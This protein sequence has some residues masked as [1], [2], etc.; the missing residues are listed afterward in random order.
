MDL[1]EFEASLVYRACSRTVRAILRNPV[2]KTKK[3]NNKQQKLVLADPHKSLLAMEGK[4][5][6]KSQK[7]T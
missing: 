1:C 4:C 7:E 3:A 6:I 5:C 2:L